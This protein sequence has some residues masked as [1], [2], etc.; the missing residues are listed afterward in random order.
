MP[1]ASWLAGRLCQ[2]CLHAYDKDSNGRCSEAEQHLFPKVFQV[3]N[4]SF[5]QVRFPRDVLCDLKP[6]YRGPCS[7]INTQYE[8]KS[9]VTH[10][11]NTYLLNTHYIQALI[12]GPGIQHRMSSVEFLLQR[13]G[14]SS[15]R[16]GGPVGLGVRHSCVYIL[17]LQAE[18]CPAPTFVF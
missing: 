10:L 3:N 14:Y 13:A 7:K 4:L 18:P 5:L 9:G 6:S 17:L 11:F 1:V 16:W 2:S 8:E 15:E 12:L